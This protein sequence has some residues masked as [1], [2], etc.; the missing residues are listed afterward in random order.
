MKKCVLLI[1]LLALVM[2]NYGQGA[3]ATVE[4]EYVD[5]GLPS[6]TKWATMNI[7][8]N[9]PEEPG[10]FFAWGEI[11]AKL[12]FTNEGYRFRDDNSL[13]IKYTTKQWG[14]RLTDNKRILEAEDDVATMSWGKAW[15]MPTYEEQTELR[16]LCT[17][18]WTSLNG[19]EGCMVTGPNGNSIFLPAAGFGER[20]SGSGNYW[21]SS[22][23]T[24]DDNTA[25]CLIFNR[26]EPVDRRYYRFNGLSV[27]PVRAE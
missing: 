21:S 7:G 15:R 12:D 6:G 13:M 27:R 18:Q 25:Y 14:K 19:M 26:I 23:Y 2:A 9:A 11:S 1:M 22:L 16:M 10:D 8:A 5:L 24:D 4:H 17:W 20:K 3:D